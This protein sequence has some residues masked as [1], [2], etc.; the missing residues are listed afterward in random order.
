MNLKLPSPT[1]HIDNLTPFEYSQSIRHMKHHNQLSAAALQHSIF[2]LAHP[3]QL[4][5]HG[6]LCS[7]RNDSLRAYDLEHSE[8]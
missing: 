2:L 4:P 6:E 1:S 7:S 5:S 3:V 8:T